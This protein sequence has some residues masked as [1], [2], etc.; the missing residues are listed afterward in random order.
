MTDPIQLE[1]VTI[2][3]EQMASITKLFADEPT[4]AEPILAQQLTGEVAVDYPELITYEGLLD[5]TAPLFDTLPEFKNLDPENRQLSNSQIISLFAVDE[6]GD[7]IQEGTFLQGAKREIFPSVFSLAGATTGAKIGAKLQAPIPPAGPLA[8]ATK[9]AIPTVTTLIGAFGGYEAGDETTDLLFGPEKPVTPGSRAAYESGKTVAGAVGWL[10][11]PYMISKN[12]AFGGAQYLDNINKLFAKPGPI[13]AAELAQPGVAG[14]LAKGKAPKTA[15]YTASIERFL[16]GTGE[17]ARKS[18]IATGVL[19]TAAAAGTGALA[20]TAET[21]DPGDASTRLAAEVVGGVVPSILGAR[22]VAKAPETIIKLK[23]FVGDVKSG[24]FNL[25][26][27]RQ[28]AAVN[29]IIDIL[30]AQGEDVDA[31]IQRLA[32]PDFDKILIDPDTKKPITLTAGMKADSPAL[33]AIERSLS[34]TSPGLGKERAAKNEQAN[35]ALRNVIAA[36]VATGNKEAIQ[37]AAQIAEDVFSAGQSIRLTRATDRVLNAFSRVKGQSPEGNI[38]LSQR[39]VDSAI[40]VMKAGRAEERRLW[41]AVENQPINNFVDGEGNAVDQPN[42]LTAW[43]S[44]MPSTDRAAAPLNR[45]LKDLKGF[46]DDKMA[47]LAQREGVFE[48]RRQAVAKGMDLGE[49]LMGPLLT[50]TEATEMRTEALNLARQLTATGDLNAARVAYRFADGLLDDLNSVPE[51]TNAAYDIARAYS[52]SFNDIFTRAFAGRITEKGKTGAEKIA[53]ELLA[54]KLMVGGSDPTF[55]RVQQINDVGNFAIQQGFEG[56][57]DTAATIR[58]TQEMIIRNARAAAFD[59]QTGEINSKALRKWMESNKDLMD[60]FPALKA[61]LENAETANLLLK[62]RET[63]SASKEKALRGQVTFRDLLSST[64]DSPTTAVAKALGSGNKA[65]MRSLNNLS[66]V[67]KDAPEELQDSAR[68]GLKSSMLEWAMTKGGATSRSFSPRNMYDNLFSKIPNAISD[69]SVMDWMVKNDLIPEREVTAVKKYLTEMVRLEAMDA[70]GTIGDLA[71]DAG[72]MLDF[73]LR[74]SGSALGARAQQL[75]PGGG[76][77]GSLIAASAGSKAMRNI[78]NKVPESMKLDVMSDLMENP[79]LLAAMMRKP[80]N[81][82]E[83]LRIAQRVEKLLI[84]SGFI[85]ARRAAPQVLKAEEVEDLV[86]E[87][88][89]EPTSVGPVSSV[90]PTAIPTPPPV[91]AQ[92]VAQPT[93]TLASVSPPPP[94]QAPSGPVDRT[95]Y[96]AMFPNDPASAL[97]RQQGIGSLM[98]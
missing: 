95:R 35:N 20:Y 16:S 71:K 29:R 51:G 93:T 8:I 66:Q 58:G 9:V 44:S 5:G 24:E 62:Q 72:P 31:V 65:P 70:A 83:K 45:K 18:P 87:E 4:G 49:D 39:L 22:L 91:P 82:R 53:P 37:E 60:T 12:V 74:I 46:V 19:E 63:L 77:A 76:G 57:A 33:L 41:N 78:F 73:Y 21:A 13:T 56:A 79:E 6:Q 47:E 92:P 42:F 15:R 81:D 50:V 88:D 61:D 94:P 59:S 67:I 97:I 68:A 55:L 34:Q 52:R 32:S 84:G 43:Q 75:I 17:A 98:G 89:E 30:E 69:V 11:L 54:N 27:R 85:P 23:G 2:G 90:A 36:L 14:T 96:A 25:K 38:E 48:A 1:P 26:G 80:R 86:V 28:N 10:P 3:T 7:P 40:D 64:T